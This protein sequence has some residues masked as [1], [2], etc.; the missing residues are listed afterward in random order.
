MQIKI[1]IGFSTALLLLGCSTTNELTPA[2][3]QIRF[4]DTDLDRQCFL[5]GRVTG[6]Q[7]NWL[8][9]Q[10]YAGSSMGGAENDLRNKAAAIGGNVIYGVG[11]PSATLWSALIPLDSRMTGQVYKCP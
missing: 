2:G 7:S 5:L 11:T 10:G 4:V 8:A 1:L 9:G 3:A 6:V